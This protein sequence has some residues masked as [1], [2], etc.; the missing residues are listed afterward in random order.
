MFKKLF[1]KS[2]ALDIVNSYDTELMKLQK[3]LLVKQQK[4]NE[5]QTKFNFCLPDYIIDGIIESENEKSYVNLHYLINCA[6][7]NERISKCNG[8]LLKRVYSFN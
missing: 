4:A 6:V 2:Q 5:I 8:E 3:E 7:V 1:K